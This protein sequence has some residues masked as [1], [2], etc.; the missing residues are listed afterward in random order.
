[1]PAAMC[2]RLPL[3]ITA[4]HLKECQMYIL[5]RFVNLIFMQCSFF[6]AGE[7]L[8]SEA[9]RL[10]RV[11]NTLWEVRADWERIADKLVSPG[12]REVRP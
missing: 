8:Q 10:K 4:A 1:M 7:A 5:N 9:V 11:L 2:T 3:R 6:S 12:T